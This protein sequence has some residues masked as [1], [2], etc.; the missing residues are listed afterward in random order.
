[1]NTIRRRTP[2]C[3]GQRFSSFMSVSSKTDETRSVAVGL[4][5]EG[6]DCLVNAIRRRTG[7]ARRFAGSNAA[8]IG[9]G[10][11]THRFRQASSR[12]AGRRQRSGS[13]QNVT[14]NRAAARLSRTDRSRPSRSD[15]NVW[16]DSIRS[17]SVRLAPGA[18]PWNVDVRR[19]L[20]CRRS[21]QYQSLMD[22]PKGQSPNMWRGA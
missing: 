15:H 14:R 16:S 22:E 11:R 17:I 1:M 8:R 20:R 6:I 5:D 10:P 7:T 9:G 21:D 12:T 2:G 19:R 13:H 4:S 3:S 18:C